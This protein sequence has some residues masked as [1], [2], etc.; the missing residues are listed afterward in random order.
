MQTNWKGTSINALVLLE[1]NIRVDIQ[2]IGVNTRGIGLIRQQ[3]A[4]T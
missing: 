1:N 3:I 4:N 2:G